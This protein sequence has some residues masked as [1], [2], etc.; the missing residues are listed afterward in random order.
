MALV[1]T[2][3]QSLLKDTAN[4]FMLVGFFVLPIT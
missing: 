3:E 4:E 2:E 1:L